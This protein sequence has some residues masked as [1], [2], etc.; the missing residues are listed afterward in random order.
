M[1]TANSIETDIVCVGFGPATGGFLTTLSKAIADAE[2]RPLLESRAIP[3]MPLQ[4]ICY[5]R[6]DD[7]SFGV[8]GVVSKL[9]S[10]KESF[11][12]LNPAEISMMCPVTKEKVFYLLDP[13]GASRRSWSVRTLDKFINIFKKILPYRDQAVQLPYT[14]PFLSK[15]GGM[16]LSIGQLNQWVGSQVMSTGLVQIWPGSPVSEALIENNKVV[17]VKLADQGVDKS[18]KPDT[19]YMPGM[20]V[21]SAFTVVGDGPIGAVGQKLN[22]CFGMPQG[23]HAREW[24]IGMKMVVELAEDSG[25]EAGTVFHTFGYPEPEIFGFLY[26]HPDRMASVGIFVP[27]WF[28]CPSRNAYR[29]LQHWMQH[30]RLW[31]HLKGSQ[32]RSWGA[33]SLQESGRRG[34]PYLTGDGYARIGEGSGSTNVL[35]GSGVDEAWATGVQLAEAV[36]EIWKAGKPFTKDIL[37]ETYSKKR[38]HSWVG[39]GAKVAEKSRDGFGSGFLRGLAGMGLSGMTGGWLHMPGKLKRPH[40]RIPSL[41]DYYKGKITPEEIDEIRRQS[42]ASG[43]PLYNALMDKA[44]WPKIEPDGKLFVSHQDILL[45]GGKVQ[46]AGGFADHV[47]FKERALC[48]SCKEQICIEGC[49]GQAITPSG[50]DGDGAPAFDREKCVHCGVCLWNCSKADK[51]NPERS[52]V[53]FNAGAGG[54]HSTIN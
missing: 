18:G 50:P 46:A 30:P 37:Q 14:P 15:H 5:E 12:S 28:D 25:L 16:I 9:R 8:S 51:N 38:Q 36:I 32:M 33:K 53:L 31:Q 11:P 48:R 42:S 1:N 39:K 22:D 7:I 34:E 3:G 19:G 35:T 49:S 6:A 29:Y 10:V 52:N 44:G 17:G 2:G 24:A 27:S 47:V 4:V 21:K 20:D 40:E 54:L 26:V 41:E 43:V 13:V 23:H 45:V